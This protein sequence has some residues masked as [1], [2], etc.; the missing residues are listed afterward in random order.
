MNFEEFVEKCNKGFCSRQTVKS[1]EC[2]K[3]YKQESCYRK[4]NQKIEK[5]KIKRSEQI[6]KKFDKVVEIDEQWES[7]KKEIM[8]RDNAECCFY[9]KLSIDQK[10]I[11]NSH[12]WGDF[13]KLDGAHVFGKGPFPHMKYDADNVYIL[14]RYIHKCLDEATDPFTQKSI[15]GDEVEGYWKFIIS[16][17]KYEEL[18]KRS[19]EL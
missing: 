17:D 6:Q 13:K 12:L 2:L 18:R 9:S 1:K 16:E 11:I 14:Y 4:Y 8:V 10:R 7:L 15:T 19:R 3:S 5:D